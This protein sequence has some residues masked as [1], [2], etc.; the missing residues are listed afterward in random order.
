MFRYP[1]LSVCTLAGALILTGCTPPDADTAG[2][3]A[4]PAEQAAAYD[5]SRVGYY[6]YG[7]PASEAE[8]AGWDIDIRPDGKGLPEGVDPSH[9]STLGL[10]LVS[11]LA[12]QLQANVEFESGPGL[13]VSIEF[14][15]VEPDAPGDTMV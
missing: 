15:T 9:A 3:S 4:M 12:E 1:K 14:K 2:E 13:A 11:A 8:I 5:E 10:R 6:G 7:A